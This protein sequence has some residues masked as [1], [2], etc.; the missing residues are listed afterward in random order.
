M[1]YKNTLLATITITIFIQTTSLIAGIETDTIPDIMLTEDNILGD[2]HFGCSV[3][4]AGD[5]NGDGYEDIIVGAQHYDSPKGRAYIYFGD[6]SMD[7]IPDVI[8]EGDGIDSHFGVSVSCAGDVDGDGYDDVIVGAYFFDSF[9]GRSYVY[10]GGADMD[11]LA[12]VI[13]EGEGSSN[14]FGGTVSEAGDLNND[15]YD[16]IIIGASGF[17]NNRGRSYIYFGGSSMDSIADIKMH[18]EASGD[19][20]G[21]CVSNAGDINNDGYD[22]VIIGSSHH[23]TLTGIAY[24]YL[25]GSTMDNIADIMFIG[26]EKESFFSIDVSDLGDVNNDGYDDVIIGAYRYNNYTGRSYIFYGSTNMDSIADVIM[27]GKEEWDVYSRSLSGA[28]DVN[29][30]G[31]D[32]ILVGAPYTNS[33]EGTS[34]LYYGG[35]V[36][37]S[38]PDVIFKGGV[39]DFGRSLSKAGDLNADGFDDIIISVNVSDSG[40]CYIYFGDVNMDSIP[41]KK[42]IAE[43]E[44]NLFGNSVSTAGDM[45]NDGFDDLIIGARGYN[46]YEGRSYIYLGGQEPDSIVNVVLDGDTSRECFGNSVSSAG[47]INGDGYDDVIVGAPYNNSYKG[48][49]YIYFGSDTVDSKADVVLNGVYD[50]SFFGSSVSG[51]GDVNGDGY[52]DILVA[53]HNVNLKT[54]HCYVYFGGEDMDTVADI[55]ISG[56]TTDFL[57]GLDVS[58]ADVNGDGYDDIIAGGRYNPT[59]LGYCYIYFG[60]ESMDSIADKIM[61]GETFNDKFGMCVSNAGDV[62]NDGY[63][64][65]IVGAREYNSY[66]GRSYIFY[67][68]NSMDT[69]ADVI[70]EGKE[71]YDDFGTCVSNIGD[72]N[73]DGYDDVVVGV[74]GINSSTGQSYIFYGGSSMD[75]IADVKMSGEGE[76]NHF[77]ISVSG[78]GDFNGDRGNDLIIGAQHYPV[79]GKAYLYYGVPIILEITSQPI[80][81][82]TCEYIQDTIVISGNCISEY[83]WQVSIDNGVSY[84]DIS[85]DVEYSGYN[86]DSLII[87]SPIIDMDQY[88]YRCITYG[89]SNDSIISDTAILSVSQAFINVFD[90][91]ICEG[92]SIAW[93]GFSYSS[94]GAYRDVFSTVNDC[95]SIYELNLTVNPRYSYTDNDT[96]CSGDTIT[97]HEEKFAL[98]GI[99]NLSYSTIN[100]CDS[101][102]QLNL[103]VQALPT[104]GF[105]YLTNELE[106]VFTNESEG[107]TSFQWY[108]GDEASSTTLNPTHSY[109][110][111]GDYTVELIASNDYCTGDTATQ[112]IS[113][114]TDIN[115]ALSNSDIEL[116]PNP[117]NDYIYIMT[118]YPNLVEYIELETLCG[119]TLEIK[120][121]KNTLDISN[122]TSGV[123]IVRIHTKYNRLITRKILKY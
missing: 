33:G 117:S 67:G 96:I 23:D 94:S 115:D 4:N 10:F 62:N 14:Y 92:E 66:T 89:Y 27:E 111:Q 16:D 118:D 85:N 54:G 99:Y 15:G 11:S 39:K 7:T 32:D 69:I 74:S 79:N 110:T 46:N 64:D 84:N 86:T 75:S 76:S 1:Y 81:S 49:S 6:Q 80:H 98:E 59:W 116:Y 109:S 58:F 48:R 112:I 28:G 38:I 29:N 57:V 36:V 22:D 24:I 8:L 31:F 104:A 88:Q 70:M 26:E 101:T 30:D 91:L 12:D 41:D 121:D 43:G 9:R 42:L 107:A 120:C 82:L 106:V 56:E 90:T 73:A 65:V 34:Y 40:S 2:S 122:L 52:H 13:M 68:G 63:E 71:S 21:N 83:R 100:S 53:E 78:A 105:T 77:G 17:N 108:F 44:D 51:A 35:A 47:D 87:L 19:R 50:K 123:Y 3:S 97:W 61:K 114:A 45:N 102:Y 103:V 60:G 93:R 72:I 37:D 55:V 119:K 20:F 18:G 25:G 5:V 95:D 113:L